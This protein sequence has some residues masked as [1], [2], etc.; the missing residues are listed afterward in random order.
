MVSLHFCTDEAR[1]AR[2]VQSTRRGLERKFPA[3]QDPN[4]PAAPCSPQVCCRAAT[5]FAIRCHI[6]I[7]HRTFASVARPRSVVCFRADFSEWHLRTSSFCSK[8]RF[9]NRFVARH[10][11]FMRLCGVHKLGLWLTV[12]AVPLASQKSIMHS[13]Q[14]SKFA[15]S[16]VPRPGRQPVR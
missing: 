6:V 5:R 8:M 12:L 4:G 3:C 16:A 15:R 1:C 11:K 9:H 2:L 10:C 14:Q 7:F 13:L